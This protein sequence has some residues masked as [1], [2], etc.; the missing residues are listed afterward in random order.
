MPDSDNCSVFLGSTFDF[1]ISFTAIVPLA[2]LLG[3]AT[4]QCSLKLGDSL[5]ALLNATFGSEQ[6]FV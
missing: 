4:E 6:D 2:A 3:E 1:I 5:G